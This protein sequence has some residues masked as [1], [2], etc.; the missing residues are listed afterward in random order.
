MSKAE[1]ART[2]KGTPYLVPAWPFITMGARTM[3]FAEEEGSGT[4]P[5]ANGRVGDFRK[6]KNTVGDQQKM[7][8]TTSKT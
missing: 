7:S 8:S 5:E 2:G 3:Q 1:R 4:A 6:K